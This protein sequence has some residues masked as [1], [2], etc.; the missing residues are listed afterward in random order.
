MIPKVLSNQSAVTSIGRQ[1]SA[2]QA[3][4]IEVSRI[5]G[6][7]DPTVF[8][9]TKKLVFVPCPVMINVSVPTQHFGSGS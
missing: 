8:H 4:S 7:L 1:L 9:Q 2:K 5:V 3:S 6:N